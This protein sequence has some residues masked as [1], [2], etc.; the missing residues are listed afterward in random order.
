MLSESS[1]ESLHCHMQ[2][3][4]ACLRSQ[5]HLHHI[6][7]ELEFGGESDDYR[8]LAGRLLTCESLY[9]VSSN[10]KTQ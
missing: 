3:A 2:Q 1:S 7:P 8:P 4:P 9:L 6:T 10:H 5:D